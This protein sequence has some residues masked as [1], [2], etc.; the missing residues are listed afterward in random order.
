MYFMNTYL[1]ENEDIKRRKEK[2]ITK[3]NS[4]LLPEKP[5]PFTDCISL[6]EF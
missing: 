1:T 4:R 5:D 2:P 6:H 3:L